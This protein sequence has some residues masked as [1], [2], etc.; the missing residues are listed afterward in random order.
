VGGFVC[1]TGVSGSGKST[2]VNEILL[3]AVRQN[4]H[5]GKDRPGEHARINGLHRIDRIIEVDQS[6]IGRTPRSN[7]ATYTGIFDD[8]RKVFTQT[9][10]AK[11]RGYK[12]GRFSFNVAR[13]GGQVGGGGRCEACQGQGLKKIEMHFLPDVYV[14]C[15]VCEGSG[16]T[17]RRSRWPTA[18]RTSRMCST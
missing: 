7:P 10:E 16:T 11:I 8:I 3:K 2:L 6:P 15:E 12:P 9:K 5:G 17:A 1:V 14:E 4:L 18:G 13:A